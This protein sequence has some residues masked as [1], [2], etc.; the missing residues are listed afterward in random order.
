MFKLKTPRDSIN[1]FIIHVD[2]YKNCLGF[3]DLA[4]EHHAWLSTQ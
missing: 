1:Q 4:F 3:K 2:K